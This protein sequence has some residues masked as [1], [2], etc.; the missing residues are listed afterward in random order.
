MLLSGWLA[1]VALLL[2]LCED[3]SGIMLGGV[4]RNAP[5]SA[6]RGKLGTSRRQPCSTHYTSHNQQQGMDSLAGNQQNAQQATN[7]SMHLI[8]AE[9]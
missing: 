8:A 3:G 2:L 4:P 1:V 9:T 7:H 5:S 6:S